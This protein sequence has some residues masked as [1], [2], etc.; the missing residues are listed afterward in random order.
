VKLPGL[1]QLLR[2]RAAPDPPSQADIELVESYPGL[3][4]SLARAERELRAARLARRPHTEIRPRYDELDRLLARLTAAALAG[5]RVGADP[6]EQTSGSWGSQI[7]W[8]CARRDHYRLASL[9]QP[10]P[11]TS[12]LA[13]PADRAAAPRAAG[14]DFP[15]PAATGPER[16]VA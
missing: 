16:P 7:G 11:P 12:P 8:L 1:D 4:A 2:R 10:S 3:L 15:P 14:L 5:R 9:D 13:S 6:P